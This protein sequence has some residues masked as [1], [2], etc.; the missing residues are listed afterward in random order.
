[1]DGGRAFIPLA[2]I[3]GNA[4]LDYSKSGHS[5]KLKEG[6][7]VGF[8]KLPEYLSKYG[9]FNNH[10]YSVLSRDNNDNS[11]EI[12][13]PHNKLPYYDFSVICDESNKPL[14]LN[15]IP[16]KTLLIK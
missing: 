10:A 7:S 5:G 6:Y 12:K 14:K 15:K 16:I 9:L 11:I 4:T 2:A 1:M 8:I 13:N 3:T